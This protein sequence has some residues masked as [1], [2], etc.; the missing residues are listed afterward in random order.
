[1]EAHPTVY[2]KMLADGWDKKPNV[3][4]VHARWQDVVDELGDFDAV[5]FDTFDDVSGEVGVMGPAR[6]SLKLLT[7]RCV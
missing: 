3:R 5:F 7:F 6:I 2:Q 1:M 4:I